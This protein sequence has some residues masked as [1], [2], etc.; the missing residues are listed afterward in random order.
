MPENS[1]T[2]SID[3][4]KSSLI[5]FI[6]IASVGMIWLAA[7]LEPSEKKGDASANYP[8]STATRTATAQVY[9]CPMPVK[10]LALPGVWSNNVYECPGFDW[11]FYKSNTSLKNIRALISVRADGDDARI[12]RDGILPSGVG[13]AEQ[14]ETT[15]KYAQVRS[16]VLFPVEMG[17]KFVRIIK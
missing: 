15:M 17:I 7:S 13:V 10:V 8:S 11:I 6:V 9:R 2:S 3:K 4:V 5:V 16:N 12:R 14:F 1:S